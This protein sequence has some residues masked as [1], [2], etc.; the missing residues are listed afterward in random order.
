MSTININRVLKL[1]MRKILLHSP[2]LLAYFGPMLGILFLNT[3]GGGGGD[4]ED[5]PVFTVWF[6]VFLLGGGFIFTSASIPEL[7]T[8]DGRQAYLTL[9]ASNGEKWLATWF[10][11]GP[12]FVVVFSLTYCLLTLLVEGILGIFNGRD[13]VYFNLFTKS[14]WEMVKVYLLVVHPIALV[15]A[16]TFNRHAFAK[17]AGVL[18]IISLG[19]AA[20]VALTIRIVYHEKFT[21]FFT[22]TGSINANPMFDYDTAPSWMIVFSTI[23]ILAVSYF[24]FHEKEV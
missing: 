20:V 6:G 14:T 7:D 12:L 9:P 19:F 3:V 24:R 16:I 1:V 22:P 10:Y 18:M 8:P 23:V 15:G 21:G 4:M 17:T 13:F 11:S 5:F 2:K